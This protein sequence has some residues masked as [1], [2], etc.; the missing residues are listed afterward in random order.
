MEALR[1]TFPSHQLR[2][3]VPAGE[4]GAG[5]RAFSMKSELEKG[6]DSVHCG[7][8]GY[9]SDHS[10]LATACRTYEGII[11]VQPFGGRCCSYWMIG[12]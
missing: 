4:L 8:I 1:N 7:M 2:S 5:E 12:Y 10:H 11:F 3:E 6:D 9:E